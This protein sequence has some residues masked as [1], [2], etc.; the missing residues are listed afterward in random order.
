MAICGGAKFAGPANGQLAEDEGWLGLG[1]RESQQLFQRIH[2][3]PRHVARV[4]QG[5]VEPFA[6]LLQAQTDSGTLPLYHALHRIILGFL[7]A[8]PPDERAD[9]RADAA[10]VFLVSKR[11]MRPWQYDLAARLGVSPATPNRRFRSE[12]GCSPAEYMRRERIKTEKLL[13]SSLSRNGSGPI[14]WAFVPA[15]TS[16][17]SIKNSPIETPARIARE[18]SNHDR[19]S[20]SGTHIL[21]IGCYS[22]GGDFMDDVGAKACVHVA[23]MAAPA[24]SRRT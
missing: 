6:V 16:P 18:L 3:H 8:E 1:H 7:N 17:P 4:G 2:E 14:A 21:C 5:L 13:A 19:S 20:P 11:G 22:D 12:M 24:V 10:G 15:S 9:E 23:L